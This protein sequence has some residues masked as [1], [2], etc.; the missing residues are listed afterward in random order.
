MKD[1][2]VVV[3]IHE[4][5]LKH[6]FNI[7][8]RFGEVKKSEFFNV[9]VMK[10]HDVGEM[11]EG[12]RKL[13]VEDPETAGTIAR[14]VPA[15]HTFNF[16]TPEEFEEQ[17][18]ETVAG[19]IPELGWKSFHVRMHRRGFKGKLSSTK[20]EQFL[21]GFIL[22]S[23]EETGTPGRVTFEDPDVIIDIETVGQRAGLSRW[24]RDDLKR[25][26]FLKLD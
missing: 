3:N 18:K 20:E 12:L 17:A 23:L 26:P 9:L 5:R 6:A 11:M 2:N 1:W 16:Q 7:L 19:W 4:R 13:T 15:S 14:L 10:V 25:Y 24:S 22:R 8:E 21:D